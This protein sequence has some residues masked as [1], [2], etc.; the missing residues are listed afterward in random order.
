LHRV[1]IALEAIDKAHTLDTFKRYIFS[2]LFS[3]TYFAA[4]W[5]LTS[6]KDYYG[7]D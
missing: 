1:L 5:T 7:G 2:A 6:R 4:V 3:V